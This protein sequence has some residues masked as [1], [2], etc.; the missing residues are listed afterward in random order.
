M[1][2][3]RNAFTLAEVL[4]TLVIIGVIGA[5]TV[6]ALIQ[7]AQKQEYVSALKK[8][9]STLS[10]VTQQ[11][12]SE[13]G[14][15]KC[16]G[17]GW[18]CT[19]DDF[20]ETYKKHLNILKD[21]GT[22][23]DTG[24][25]PQL[26]KWKNG[27]NWVSF[28]NPSYSTGAAMYKLVLADGMQIFFDRNQFAPNCDYDSLNGDGASSICG[29]RIYVD[30]NGTKSPNRAGYDHFRFVLKENGLQPAGCEAETC[31]NDYGT[32][33]ACKVLT[34]NAINY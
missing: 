18:G 3:R 2:E 9:Y 23:S 29:A 33:C 13:E 31:N 27:A 22:G 14:S 26:I 7:N 15:P 5:L 24:C 1:K 17:G 28:D 16:D 20:V 12:I 6:P 11:I 25:A 19:F 4:I 10:Q 30:T 32:G 8:A 34:E 21:C